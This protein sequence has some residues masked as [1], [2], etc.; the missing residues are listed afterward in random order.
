[1]S[2]L[3]GKDSSKNAPRSAAESSVSGSG[4]EEMGGGSGGAVAVGGGSGGA[5][6]VS[7]DGMA[8]F[9]FLPIAEAHRA[10][11]GCDCQ[12]VTLATWASRGR[13]GAGPRCWDG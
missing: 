12:H 8:F 7:A 2:R 11:R 10:R 1:M 6:A 13:A 5:C 9:V 4:A 3:S